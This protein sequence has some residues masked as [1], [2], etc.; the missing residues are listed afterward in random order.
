MEGHWKFRGGGRSQQPK[1]IRESMKEKWKF[2]GEGG[3]SIITK[4]DIFV[5]I[6]KEQLPVPKMISAGRSSSECKNYSY[7]RKKI[8]VREQKHFE[9]NK[10]GTSNNLADPAREKQIL[11][12]L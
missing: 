1:F 9:S 7:Q 5:E 2:L 4:A 6:W 10:E 8:I 3:F 11:S 12:R